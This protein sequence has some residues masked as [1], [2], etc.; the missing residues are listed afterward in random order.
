M[1]VRVCVFLLARP[2]APLQRFPFAIE[3]RRTTCLLRRVI[4]TTMKHAKGNKKKRWIFPPQS[5]V[6]LA[7]ARQGAAQVSTLNPAQV[8]LGDM[9]GAGVPVER[10]EPS[11]GDARVTARRRDSKDVLLCLRP[12]PRSEEEGCVRCLCAR[13]TLRRTAQPQRVTEGPSSSKHAS[14]RRVQSFH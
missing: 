10:W 11:S 12:P 1:C 3:H 7:R 8:P 13:P 14:V 2:F 4:V 6:L 9:P 5:A